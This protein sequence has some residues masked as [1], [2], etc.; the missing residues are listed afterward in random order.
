MARVSIMRMHGFAGALR[1][2]PKCPI[3]RAPINHGVKLLGGWIRFPYV[4]W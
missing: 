3:H 1:L 4:G 2:F